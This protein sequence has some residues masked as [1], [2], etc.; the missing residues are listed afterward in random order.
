ML[1][2]EGFYFS[3]KDNYF[4]QAFKPSYLAGSVRKDEFSWCS[5]VVTKVP[6]DVTKMAFEKNQLVT[7]SEEKYIHTA[8][9][10]AEQQLADSSEKPGTVSMDP[11][12]GLHFDI[13]AIRNN[14]N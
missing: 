10:E 9:E 3:I 14:D 8:E 12:N 2:S 4:F 6:Y 7:S 11:E 13:K 1:D 5:P